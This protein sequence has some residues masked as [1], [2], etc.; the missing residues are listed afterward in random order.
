MSYTSRQRTGID[1]SMANK[2]W[3][4]QASS[5]YGSFYNKEW[6]RIPLYLLP[7][8]GGYDRYWSQSNDIQNI[9]SLDYG[10]FYTPSTEYL[11]G[12]IKQV[13]QFVF[14][15]FDSCIYFIFTVFLFSREKDFYARYKPWVSLPFCFFQGIF[16]DHKEWKN[17]RV[18][19]RT[20]VCVDFINETII[21]NKSS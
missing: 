13:F 2:N 4:W 14:D 5:A 8:Y 20:W 9:T 10:K 7:Y 12:T 15:S 16:M 18:T 1:T 21:K 17:I 6:S 3:P 19:T 11:V